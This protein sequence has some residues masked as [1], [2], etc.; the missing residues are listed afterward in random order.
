MGQLGAG[1]VR[2]ARALPA[3]G[4]GSRHYVP[5]I[6]SCGL[7]VLFKLG[8]PLSACVSRELQRPRGRTTYRSANYI[9]PKLMDPAE[10]A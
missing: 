7:S 9:G 2:T 3:A 8:M 4:F 1:G 5:R 6:S 10:P